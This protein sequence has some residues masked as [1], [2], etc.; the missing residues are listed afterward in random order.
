MTTLEQHTPDRVAATVAVTG[1]MLAVTA[2][3][4]LVTRG[5]LGLD[6]TSNARPVSVGG[7]RRPALSVRASDA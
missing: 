4:L 6:A 1:T 7:P 3:L 2:V 5:Q